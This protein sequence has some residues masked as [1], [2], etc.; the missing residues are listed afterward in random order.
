MIDA[1]CHF[2]DI[3]CVKGAYSGNGIRQYTAGIH[4]QSVFLA[5]NMDQQPS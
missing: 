5:R 2:N 1:I 4:A 3:I